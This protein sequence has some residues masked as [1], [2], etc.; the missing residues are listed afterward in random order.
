MTRRRRRKRW[1]KKLSLYETGVIDSDGG[2][3]IHMTVRGTRASAL[4]K[5]L[6]DIG[7]RPISE[8]EMRQKYP[9]MYD[10]LIL[11]KIR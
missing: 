9:E 6:S 5:F 1:G 3:R 11:R 8:S 10:E 7:V 4:R 2:E